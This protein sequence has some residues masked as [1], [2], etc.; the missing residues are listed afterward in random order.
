MSSGQLQVP[1]A[2]ALVVT[3]AQKED[4]VSGPSTEAAQKPTWPHLDLRI[5][6]PEWRE[7][8]F[9]LRSPLVVGLCYGNPSKL[10]PDQVEF[11]WHSFSWTQR[12][13]GNQPHGLIPVNEATAPSQGQ[14]ALG[15]P[16][17]PHW[18]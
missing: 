13:A 18:G 5:Q 12:K 1:K 17:R 2:A 3:V 8:E 7:D 6:L 9:L 14:E 11:A 10:R 15:G 16:V 4:A